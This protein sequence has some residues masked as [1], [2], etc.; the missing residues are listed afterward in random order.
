MNTDFKWKSWRKRNLEECFLVARKSSP[1]ILHLAKKE[2]GLSGKAQTTQNLFLVCKTF[3]TSL[4][5]FIGRQKML[6]KSI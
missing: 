2:T 4:R 3:Q 5:L 1:K 6:K